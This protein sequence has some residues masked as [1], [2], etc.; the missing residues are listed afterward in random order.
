MIIFISLNLIVTQSLEA[1]KKI[2]EIISSEIWLDLTERYV[3][4]MQHY[5]STIKSDHA[6]DIRELNECNILIIKSTK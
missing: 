2:I 5:S 1:F 6:M 4:Y 3:S